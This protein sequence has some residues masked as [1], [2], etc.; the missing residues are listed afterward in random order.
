MTS[1]PSSNAITNDITPKYK[2]VSFL[3]SGHAIS[4]A[5]KLNQLFNCNDFTVVKMV[6][7]EQVF[8]KNE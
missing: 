1:I 6:P 8:P 2:K 5:K 7:G 4:L 3:N